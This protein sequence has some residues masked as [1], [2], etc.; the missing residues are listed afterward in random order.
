MTTRPQ[1]ASS[2]AII[3]RHPGTVYR[4]VGATHPNL[5]ARQG[6]AYRDK[7][8]AQAE[9]VIDAVPADSFWPRSPTTVS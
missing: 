4:I 7:L 3:A 8:I 5:V 1:L 2:P 9:A 6:E